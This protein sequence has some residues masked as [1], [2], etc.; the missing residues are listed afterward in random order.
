VLLHTQSNELLPSIE[1]SRSATPALLPFDTSTPNPAAALLA[2]GFG[3]GGFD[4]GFD[5]TAAAAGS[6]SLGSNFGG[7]GIGGG[8]GNGGGGGG[9][10]QPTDLFDILDDFKEPRDFWPSSCPAGKSVLH[11]RPQHMRA[12]DPQHCLAFRR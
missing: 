2:P 7:G 6:L 11:S 1:E 4:D 3:G 12:L 5:P 8:G 10:S 9:P